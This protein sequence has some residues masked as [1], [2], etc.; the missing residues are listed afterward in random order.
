M[1]N[2]IKEVLFTEEQL[3]QKVAELGAQITADYQGKNPLIVSVL[4]GSVVFMADLMRAITLPLGIDFMVVSSYGKG[5]KTTG[6]VKIVLDLNIPL[7][8]Y[9]LL[10]VEDILDSGKTLHYLMEVLGARNPKSI[11]ICTLFDKPER[12]E[13]EVSPTY[14]GARIPDAFIVGYGLDYAGKYRNLP[15]VG[16]LKP[17]VYGEPVEK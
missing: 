4:K 16:V 10:I 1:K 9:D 3:K 6:V 13:A 15:F 2:D 5:V 12:R 14:V 17:Q 8:E 11:R 7:E